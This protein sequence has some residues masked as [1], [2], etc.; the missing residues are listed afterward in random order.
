MTD[1]NQKHYLL[2]HANRELELA[3]ATDEEKEAVTKC[4]EY[5]I[6]ITEAASGPIMTMYHKFIKTYS[7]KLDTEIA[8]DS[9]IYPI[10]QIL[11]EYPGTDYNKLFK[12]I[13]LLFNESILTPLTGNDDEWALYFNTVNPDKNIQSANIRLHNVFK[14]KDGTA[15]IRGGRSIGTIDKRFSGIVTYQ[16]GKIS[17]VDIDFPYTP[18]N[19]DIVYYDITHGIQYPFPASATDLAKLKYLGSLLGQPL[20]SDCLYNE[21]IM[22]KKDE[23]SIAL[24]EYNIISI[25]DWSDRH[26]LIMDYEIVKDPE[27]TKANRQKYLHAMMGNRIWAMTLDKEKISDKVYV[28]TDGIAYHLIPHKVYFPADNGMSWVRDTEERYIWMLSNK[29]H[30]NDDHYRVYVVK[31]GMNTISISL[32]DYD[33]TSELLRQYR[34]ENN[35]PDLIETS[36]NSPAINGTDKAKWSIR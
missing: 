34:D 14:R 36:S 4:L 28:G 19:H 10:K 32:N 12:W 31:R 9:L 30:A 25:Y 3:N 2:V 15:F 23:L 24:E 33:D 35:L 27:V 22:L 8:E 13:S 18:T 5:L 1:I 26:S 29:I 7:D 6:K 16:K 17:N 21:S 11:S 20:W